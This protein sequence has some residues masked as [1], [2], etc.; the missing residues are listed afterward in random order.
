MSARLMVELTCEECKVTTTTPG[1]LTHELHW[2]LTGIHVEMPEGWKQH[3]RAS[4]LHYCP[5][6]A[7]LAR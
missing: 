7:H 2:S 6:H 3:S 4:D 1:V 5:K